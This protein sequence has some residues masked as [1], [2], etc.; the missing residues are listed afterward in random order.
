MYPGSINKVTVGCFLRMS[1]ELKNNQQLND[2]LIITRGE[3]F[4]IISAVET[5]VGPKYYILKTNNVF[6]WVSMFKDEFEMI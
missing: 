2:S 6:G 5:S 3:L 4:F 1:P